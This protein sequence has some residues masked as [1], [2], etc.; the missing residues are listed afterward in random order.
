MLKATMIFQPSGKR[1][2]SKLGTSLIEA[3][4]KAG[5]GIQSICGGKARCGKCTIVVREGRHL[6]SS[7]SEPELNFLS[8]AELAVGYRLACCARI[9]KAGS[10]VIDV[11]VETRIN[12]YRLFVEGVKFPLQLSPI[13]KKFLAKIPKPTLTDVMPDMERLIETSKESQKI[14]EPNLDY[15]TLKVLPHV[16]REGK[17]TVTVTLWDRREVICVEPGSTAHRLHGVA[18]D[19]GTTKLACYLVDLNTGKTLA[20]TSAP[21]PQ[22]SYGEDVISRI[23][24]SSESAQHLAELQELIVDGINKLIAQACE[25]ADIK[26]QEVYD[27][28]V[29]GNTA[30]HH[31]FL[32]LNPKY[33]ALAPFPA[34]IGSSVNLKARNLG[35]HINRGAYVYTMPCVAGFV[36]ADAIADIIATEIYRS[37]KLSMCIDIGT[38]TEIMLGDKTKLVACSCASGPAF[39]G[40]HVKHGIRAA[41]GAIERVFIDPETLEV[42]YR[43]IENAKPRGICGSGMVDVIAEMLKTGIIDRSGK[44]DT[45]LETARLRVKGDIPELVIA[46]S[47]ETEGSDDIAITQKDVR[48]IQLAKAAIYAGVSV[49]MNKMKANTADIK[50]I[51]TAGA[52]GTYVDPRSAKVIGMY[53]DVSLERVK[54]VGNA[55]GSGARIAL[56]SAKARRLAEDIRAKVEYIELGADS[57]FEGEFTKALYFPHSELDRFPKV[58][59][60]IRL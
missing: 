51:F 43:T 59:R 53:P 36:G 10:I 41:T 18:V 29:V 23:T 25:K 40:A 6:L 27:M 7:V 55:A 34:V 37:N 39:E 8:Q 48:E 11:P 57:D 15:E 9:I 12:H 52:F 58:R 19:I 38:N 21:N 20:T 22:I 35:V 24:Y 50:R 14:E 31:I 32:N 16:V 4:R 33:V 60:I 3:A 17:W 5:V 47:N 56:A 13:V 54:F 44:I 26:S 46:W 28:V 1:T 49:L 45:K 42:K 2:H 30:M